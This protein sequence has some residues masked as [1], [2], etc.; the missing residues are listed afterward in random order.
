MIDASICLASK[1]A[2]S[3][4]VRPAALD[5]G[6]PG[7]VVVVVVVVVVELVELVEVDDAG[8]SVGGAEHVG[9]PV[10]CSPTAPLLIAQVTR[11]SLPC[12]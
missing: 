11:R 10:G 12:V 3:G 1:R 6:G 5:G 7:T 9:V 2:C 4:V 8:A